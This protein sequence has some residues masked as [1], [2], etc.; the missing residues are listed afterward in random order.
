[1]DQTPTTTT[2]Y[3]PPRAMGRDIADPDAGSAPAERITRLGASLLDALIGLIVVYV[4]IVLAA[5]IVSAGDRSVVAMMAG[6][7]VGLSGFLV[8]AYFT[9]LNVKR[10]GQSLGK[11][12]LGIKVVRTNGAPASVGRIFWLRN[13][14][15]GLISTIPVL[16]VVY[17]LVDLL[18]IFTESRQC[19]HDKLADTIVVKA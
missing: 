6:V 17:A 1:M 5:F 10:T 13:I 19:L 12:M 4:P 8:W 15:N 9:F 7:V 11:K 2:P 14:A 18:F 16:G 3:A